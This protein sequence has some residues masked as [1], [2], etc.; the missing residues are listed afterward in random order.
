M[1][2]LQLALPLIFLIIVGIWT[3]LDFEERKWVVF[4]DEISIMVIGVGVGILTVFGKQISELGANT[5]MLPI[6]VYLLY[7]LGRWLW[8]IGA[9]E[10][11]C[12]GI[13]WLFRRISN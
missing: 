7:V 12:N 3:A 11:I 4:A 2:I 6:A 1:P 9:V 10:A 13:K 5:V 8:E